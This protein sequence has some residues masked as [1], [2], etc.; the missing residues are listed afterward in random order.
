MLR[1]YQVA[2]LVVIALVI[3][4]PLMY[5]VLLPGISRWVIEGVISMNMGWLL[6]TYTCIT[7]LLIMSLAAWFSD[8]K[9]TA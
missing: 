4:P 5:L 3:Y 7:P 2:L 6:M 8:R 9:V 1:S